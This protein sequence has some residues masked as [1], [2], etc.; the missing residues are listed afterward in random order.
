[1]KEETQLIY[2]CGGETFH[3]YITW[4][5]QRFA[6][7]GSGILLFLFVNCLLFHQSGPYTV[8]ENLVL[9]S[10]NSATLKIIF[11]IGEEILF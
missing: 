5:A 6:T 3:F 8:L 9:S 11:F 4:K 7:D 10:S 2:H 1:M